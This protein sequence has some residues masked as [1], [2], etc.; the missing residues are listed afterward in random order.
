MIVTIFS[1]IRFK[2]SQKITNT[3]YINESSNVYNEEVSIANATTNM[4][5][6]KNIEVNLNVSL[7][8]DKMEFLHILPRQMSMI[9]PQPKSRLHFFRK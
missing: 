6:E 1:T 3:R 9:K 2:L 5:N 8:S 4:S 7:D